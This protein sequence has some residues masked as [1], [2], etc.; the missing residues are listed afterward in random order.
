MLWDVSTLYFEIDA[1][2]GFRES[3][4]STERRLDQQITIGLLI[5]ATGFRLVVNLCEGNTAESATMLPTIRRP[6]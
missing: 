1:G 2:D 4:F 5:D 6:F 3:G